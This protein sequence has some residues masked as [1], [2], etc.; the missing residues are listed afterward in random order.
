MYLLPTH[1]RE[2]CAS[3]VIRG[4]YAQ[5]SLSLQG[6]L[7]LMQRVENEP[8]LAFLVAMDLYRNGAEIDAIGPALQQAKR[9][10]DQLTRLA[11]ERAVGRDS[12]QA[13]GRALGVTRQSA[14]EKYGPK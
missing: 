8:R 14:R 5:E 4:A 1:R 12:W 2:P 7:V 10:V 3:R 9:D 13:I 6:I 11:V